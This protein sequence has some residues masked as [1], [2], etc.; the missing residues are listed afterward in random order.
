M[1]DCQHH[2]L[3][4][5]ECDLDDVA[6]VQCIGMSGHATVNISTIIIGN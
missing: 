3:G 6:G 2:P 1:L 5:A 4:I